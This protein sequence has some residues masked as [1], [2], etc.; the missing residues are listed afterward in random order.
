MEKSNKSANA[1]EITLGILDEVFGSALNGRIRVELWDGT[2]WPEAGDADVR[3]ILK[4]PGAL[5]AMLLPGTEVGMGE[6]Y[7]YDD[8]DFVGKVEAIFPLADALND[9]AK[10][11]TQK[12]NLAAR[13]RQLPQS[14]NRPTL[15]R[16]PAHLQGSR[17]SVSRDQKAVTYH[18]DVSNDFYKLFLDSN[19]VYS[20][21]YFHDT[22]DSLDKAQEQKL[23][24]ICR[25]LGLKPGQRLLDLGCGWGGLV[26]WAARHYGVEATGITLSKPQAD[27][28]NQKIAEL[29]LSQHCRVQVIDYRMVPEDQPFDALVSVGMFE[30]VGDAKLEEYFSKANRLLK[31]RGVFLNHGISSTRLNQV[32]DPESFSGAY[33]FPDGELVQ[34]ST[35]IRKAEMT[36]FETRHVESLREHYILTLRKW[37]ENLEKNHEQALK[38]VDEAT[39]RVWRLYMSGSIHGFKVR[40]QNLYQTLLVKPDGEGQSGQPLTREAWYRD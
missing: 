35:T 8:I 10:R 23:D 2:L 21:A 14:P 33:V 39:Y 15:E 20:C 9:G 40:Q 18:Y 27:Y 34:I 38:F 37:V 12:L 29:G 1:K 22:S 32:N 7:L 24:L 30:H 16:G 19:M 11:L 3:L 13:L 5:R 36:G 6:A 25:K 17:H 4:H 28:A 26:I 31:P